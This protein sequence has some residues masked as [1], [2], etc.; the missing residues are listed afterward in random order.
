MQQLVAE[1]SRIMGQGTTMH[2]GD[3]AHRIYSG[4]RNDDLSEVV[5]LWEDVDGIAAFALIWQKED[6]ADFVARIDVDVEAVTRVVTE[7]VDLVAA[8]GRIEVDVVGDDTQMIEIIERLGFRRGKEHTILTWQEIADSVVVPDS[9]FVLRT[10]GFDDIDQ[11]VAVHV[12]SFGGSWTRES[13]LE[14][15]YKPGYNPDDEIVA[16]DVDGTFTG[17]TNTWYDDLNKVGYFEPVG[18]RTD[19]HRRGV[20]TILM[21]EGMRRMSERGMTRAMVMHE[22]NDERSGGFYRANGFETLCA[23][24]PWER[25]S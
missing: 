11:L 15:M 23:I 8:E 3:V 22:A 16:V 9:G 21:R 13:Y 6:A 25:T 17:F 7:L 14:R 10:V 5:P 4:L 12:G 20:G 2:P 18:V 24:S 19:Y 1:R